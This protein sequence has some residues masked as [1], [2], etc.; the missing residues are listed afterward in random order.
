MTFNKDSL[1]DKFN[2]FRNFSYRSFT[3]ECDYSTKL[4]NL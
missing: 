2:L 3:P 4:E 1:P